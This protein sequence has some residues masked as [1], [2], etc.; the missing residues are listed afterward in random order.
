MLVM[1]IRK[2]T[3]DVDAAHVG[4]LGKEILQM[5]MVDDNNA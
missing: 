2:M 4:G 5:L 1:P 3:R